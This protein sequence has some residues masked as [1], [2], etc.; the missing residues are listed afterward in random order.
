MPGN[1]TARRDDNRGFPFTI[2]LGSVENTIA[3]FTQI[4]TRSWWKP[5]FRPAS[6]NHDRIGCRPTSRFVL[7][8]CLALPCDPDL[9]F[10]DVPISQFEVGMYVGHGPV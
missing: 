2:Q 1:A 7:G 4:Y 8:Y 10:R 3:S 5:W 9:G 6:Q